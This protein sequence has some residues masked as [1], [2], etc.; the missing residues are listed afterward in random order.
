MDSS[1]S[2]IV[3]IVQGGPSA[4]GKRYVDSKFE[5]PFRCKFILSYVSVWSNNPFYQGFWTWSEDDDELP[6]VDRLAC[7]LR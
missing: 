6:L 4:L 3:L 7:G 5:V 2:K 1:V